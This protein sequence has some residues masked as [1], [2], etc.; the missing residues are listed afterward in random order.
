MKKIN[1]S[2]IG[3][4]F[5]SLL[6]L[7]SAC[8][9]NNDAETSKGNTENGKSEENS[10]LEKANLDADEPMDELYEKAKEEGE[11]TVYSSTSA[12]MNVVEN[13]EKDYPGIK[14]EAT[15]LN[16]VEMTEKIKRE[17]ESEVYQAD[18]TF[19]SGNNG[20]FQRELIDEGLL[21]VYNP[22]SEKLIEP[23]NQNPLL[24]ITAEAYAVMYN[25][26]KNDGPPIDNWWD[27]TKPEWEGK[28]LSNDPLSSANLASLFLSFM[29]NP[30]EMAEAYEEEFGEEIVL[31]GTENAGYEFVKRLMDNGLVL[32][33]SG[34]DA[35]DGVALST[36][37]TPPLAIASTVSLRDVVNQDYNIAI[38][39]DI[40]PRVSSPI[41]KS[42]TVANNAENVN[43]AKLFIK[44][45]SG[46]DDGKAL[47]FE[48]LNTPGTWALRS[49]VEQDFGTIV[50]TYDGLNWWDRDD[51]FIYENTG[52]LRDFLLS[53]Q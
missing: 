48:P 27:L 35:V 53:I 52:E 31:N 13:F 18:L 14:V 50:T 37:D 9:E 23:Y 21:H 19:S 43:A 36:D 15:K 29:G 8:G 39:E 28:V 33:K 45:M 2:V 41:L 47:G 12:V 42:F 49:D 10:W 3:I 11:L 4:L 38:V 51:D 22:Y 7:F 20:A 34:G 44:Y 1:K 46:G 17:Q 25:T 40:K 32:L 16:D 30:E 24:Q 5:L 26:D 6:L